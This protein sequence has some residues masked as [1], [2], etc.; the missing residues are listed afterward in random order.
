V[1]DTVRHAQHLI[2]AG[3]AVVFVAVALVDQWRQRRQA[4]RQADRGMHQRPA[5]AQPALATGLAR[6][7]ATRQTRLR[8][9]AA[10]LSIV[11]G[12]IHFLVT[13]EHFQEGLAF[14]AFM[15]A[16][17]TAQV[18]AG[19]LLFVGPSR[20]VTIASVV[21]TIALAALYTVVH[22][23][24]LPFG[25]TPWVREPVGLIDIASKTAELEFLVVLAVYAVLSRQGKPRAWNVDAR[26][27]YDRAAAPVARA[28]LGALGAWL[29]QLL[30]AAGRRRPVLGRRS[31]HGSVAAN[32]L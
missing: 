16:A 31:D 5:A 2:L 7:R 18:A 29:R 28:A 3:V 32:G 14:G 13:P 4:T 1:I 30:G 15:L 20:A 23:V 11:A 19:V 17:G 27:R 12:V 10:L 6:R 25:P 8:R 26:Q 24:G 22:T 21:G 9:L